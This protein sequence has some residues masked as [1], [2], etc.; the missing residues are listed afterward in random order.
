MK[1]I[2]TAALIGLILISMGTT[3]FAVQYYYKSQNTKFLPHKDLW[4]RGVNNSGGNYMAY[5][6]YKSA[7]GYYRTAT[8]IKNNDS[9]SRSRVGT[10]NETVCANSKTVPYHTN[11]K[12]SA[13]MCDTYGNF[14]KITS[15]VDGGA[16]FISNSPYQIEE[17]GNSEK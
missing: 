13:G 9:F 4:T 14:T 5:S 2:I 6:Y 3:A 11:V 17:E 15:E 10:G 7:G 12:N 16:E 1:K 8:K